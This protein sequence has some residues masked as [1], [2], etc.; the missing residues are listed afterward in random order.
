VVS[1]LCWLKSDP[2]EEVRKFFAEEYPEIKTIMENLKVIE[3]AGY[4]TINH[5]MLPKE[6]LVE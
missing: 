3:K 2:P 4:R 5:S 1:E 6:K